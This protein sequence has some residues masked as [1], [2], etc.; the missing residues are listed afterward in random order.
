M[1]DHAEL[2]KQLSTPGDRVSREKVQLDVSLVAWDIACSLPLQCLA[3]VLPLHIA[4]LDLKASIKTV[5][6]REK[7]WGL[8]DISTEPGV[9]LPP[10][11]PLSSSAFLHCLKLETG[12]NKENKFRIRSWSNT[13][14]QLTIS[15]REY[16]LIRFKVIHSWKMWVFEVGMSPWIVQSDIDKFVSRL[17]KCS[18]SQPLRNQQCFSLRW[19][20]FYS[21]R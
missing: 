17:S 18:R 20:I 4:N 15:L 10:P 3:C 5:V 7:A 12:K 1:P 9:S 14:F 8:P 16:S 13:Y 11:H 6:F 19:S 2:D 21:I